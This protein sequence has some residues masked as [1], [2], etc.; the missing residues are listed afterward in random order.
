M[1]KRLLSMLLAVCLLVGMLPLAASAAGETSGTCGDSLTWNYDESTKTLTISGTGAMT[2][3]DG[4]SNKAPWSSFSSIIEKIVVNSGVTTIGAYAF[5]YYRNLKNCTL[6]STLKSIGNSA[7]RKSHIKTLTIPEGVEEIGVHAF[8]GCSKE[9]YSYGSDVG[10]LTSISLPSTLKT[11]GD[12]AFEL[13]T[14]LSIT[15][16][17][18]V[19]RIGERAFRWVKDVS[20]APGNSSFVMENGALMNTAKTKMYYLKKQ[21]SS[22]YTIPS[23]V[24]E[25]GECVFEDNDTLTSISVPEGVT[26]I[27]YSA[28]ASCDKLT[29]VTLP[30]TLQCLGGGAFDRC[31]AIKTIHIPAALAEMNVPWKYEQDALFENTFPSFGS[32]TSMENFTVANENTTFFS[33]DGL[34]YVNRLSNTIE[35]AQCPAAKEGSIS[36][37][38][39]ANS[40]D[41]ASQ[42]YVSAFDSCSKI[43]SL[44]I[45]SRFSVYSKEAVAINRV[46]KDCTSLQ[47]INVDAGSTKEK[48]IDGSVYDKAGKWLYAC[49][50]GKTSLTVADGTEQIQ[51][52]AWRNCEKLKYIVIPES[53]TGLHADP[54]YYPGDAKIIIYGKKGSAAETYANENPMYYIFREGTPDDYTVEPDWTKVTAKASVSYGTTNAGMVTIPS[55]GT[56]TDGETTVSGKFEVL[57]ASTVQGV[58]SHTVTVQFTVTSAG[59]YKDMTFTKDYTVEVTKKPVTVKADNK[60]KV[61]GEANPALTLTVPNGALVGGDTANDLGVTLTCAA[62]TTSPAGTPVDITGTSTSANYD[63]TVTKGTLTITKAAITGYQTAAPTATILAN[64]ANNTTANL[65]TA[66][67][68]PA[69]V[70]VTYAGGTATLPITWANAAEKYNVKGGKYTFKGTVTPGT[71]F[72][73]YNTPLT[74]TLTVTP[75]TGTLATALVSPVVIA[76]STAEKAT[77]YADFK[78]PSSVTVNCDN[79]VAAQT[80]TPEWSVPLNTLKSKRAGSKTV[81]KVTNVPKWL[82]MGELS[83]EVQVT[84]KFPVNVTVTQ[85]N[86]TYGMELAAPVAAQSAD[87]NGTDPSGAFTY[88]YIGK[89]A[90]GKTYNSSEK[91]TE[92]GSYTVTATLVSDTHAGSGSANFTIAPKALTNTMIGAIDPV[93]YT[94]SAQTPAL[95]VTDGKALVKDTDYTVEYTN[96]TNAGTATATITGKGNYTGTASKTF[97]IQPKDISSLTVTI[98][99]T[100]EVDQALLATVSDAETSGLTYAWTTDGSAV[101]G[102]TK[103]YLIL[104]GAYENKEIAATATGSDN[105]TG[106]ASSQAVTVGASTNESTSVAV[107]AKPEVSANSGNR[108]ISASVSVSTEETDKPVCLYEIQLCDS[109]GALLNTYYSLTSSYTITGLTNSTAYQVKAIAYNV[110]GASAQSDVVTVTPKTPAPIGGGGSP[111]P[112]TPDPVITENPDGSTTTTETAEDGTVTATTTWDDGKQAVAVKSPDG[113]KTITVTTATGEKVADVNIPAT[114]A[115]GKEFEDVKSGSWYES[116]VDTATGY[117]L[118]NGTS[119]TKFSPDDG[120]TRAMLATVLYNL[121]GKPEYGTDAG[122]FNDVETGKW[123]ENPVDWAYKVGVT[124][125]T[126]ATEFSPNKDITREQLVTMLYRYAEKIGAASSSKTAITGFPDG[127]KVAGYAQDA[128]Q[129]AV[130]EGFISG[131]ASGGKNYIAPQGTATR[132]EVAAVLTRFVEYLKK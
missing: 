75:V 125:G 63:V 14:E 108:Q 29:S 62:T 86:G 30:S 8:Q 83:V 32:C 50:I 116:A 23:T 17:A 120:M 76:K 66:V 89:T 93:T 25:I 54:P 60:S 27:A 42:Y 97:T 45:P 7:F 106:T 48:T 9:T 113:E 71:N 2:D 92:A 22:S 57:N 20:I 40:W 1:K 127:N 126:S 119:E 110:N 112:S 15:V 38:D 73:A 109:N 24:T 82:T 84:D 72:N 101:A 21:T 114:P 123:Y 132:A 53:V 67:N 33:Q 124:S 16:P 81:V 51:S 11:I 96:N 131:R 58:G 55:T 88:K 121:S 41:Y 68:L 28:F 12:G 91:P 37:V 64:N 18:G 69:N 19:T 79:G 56:A 35:L 49:P 65:K 130:A 105:Y 85:A 3:Y 74:A 117:G 78:L 52:E 39:G 44:E 95:T 13:D 59:D 100:P 70:T 6:P 61:Y 122:A 26:K 43:T 94:G 80:V 118:F 90:A 103:P 87:G 99:G 104:T 46:L 34:L 5:C 36:I 102:Q 98:T 31:G 128:M 111:A 4:D 115:A 77:S 129:W 47:A 107:P 10:G